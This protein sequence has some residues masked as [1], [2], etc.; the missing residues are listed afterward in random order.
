MKLNNGDILYTRP[1]ISFLYGGI[2]MGV[3]DEY[4]TIRYTGGGY[5]SG[6]SFATY[7]SIRELEE[8]WEK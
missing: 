2:Y 5:F 1:H 3:V 4:Y 6:H 8:S 7:R